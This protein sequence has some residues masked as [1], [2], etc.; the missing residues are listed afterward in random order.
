MVNLSEMIAY[1]MVIST[2]L[3]NDIPKSEP[4]GIYTKTL[5]SS[6]IPTMSQAADHPQMAAPTNI[7]ITE[8]YQ[9]R[10]WISFRPGDAISNP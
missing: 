4:I 7:S 5:P 8:P 9:G 2:Y 10:G 6:V 1:L 3:R